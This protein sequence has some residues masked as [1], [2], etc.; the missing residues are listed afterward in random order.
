[1][2]RTTLLPIA[3]LMAACVSQSGPAA[4]REAVQDFIAVRELEALDKIRTD[5]GDGFEELN[6][7]YVLYKGRRAHYLFEFSRRCW[8]LGDQRVVADERQDSRT[9]RARFE[10]FRGCRI[11]KIY[12]LTEAE[13]TELQQLGE[14]PGS[15]N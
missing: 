13:S 1:M 15:R 12:G 7:Y 11:D 4:D 2:R 6:E 14:A 5:S 8:E 10:T 3:L 9:I